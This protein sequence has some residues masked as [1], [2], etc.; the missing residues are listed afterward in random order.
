MDLLDRIRELSNQASRQ[1]EHISS[2]EATKIS[3][4]MPFIQALGYNVFDPREVVPEFNADVGTK[5]GEKV[6]YAII[7]EGEPIILIEVKSATSNLNEEHASQL[8]RYFAVTETRIGILTNGLEYRFYSDL[9]KRNH[10]DE[11][12]FLIIDILNFDPRPIGQLKKFGKTAF[13][14]DRIVTSANQLKYKREIRLQLES[15]YNN[16]SKDFVRHFTRPVYSGLL[17]ESVVSE[18]TE[19]VKQAFHEFLNDKIATRLQSAIDSTSGNEEEQDAELAED[20]DRSEGSKA[21]ETTQEELEGYFVVKSI[22]RETVDPAR[23]AIRDV[24]SYCG[25]LLDD[26]NRKPLCRFHFN[27][28]V[29]Q[30]SFFPAG[31]EIRVNVETIDDIFQYADHLIS[32][33]RHY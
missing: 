19:F 16:P 27:R 15:E 29:K 8:F 26:N 7:Q 4:V 24:R 6:D 31:E 5:K 32:A 28:L 11:K 21:I 12:P 33:A 30:V 9:E 22:L 2:E 25:S 1:L 14:V 23:I 13:D 10:M 18:F 17:R 3:F 20:L